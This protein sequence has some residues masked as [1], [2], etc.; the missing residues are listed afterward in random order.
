MEPLETMD[1]AAPLSCRQG[2]HQTGSATANYKGISREIL[3]K[4]EYSNP[5]DRDIL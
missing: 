2:S 1:L 3:P 4:Q 5:A